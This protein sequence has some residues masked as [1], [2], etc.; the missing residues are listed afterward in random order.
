MSQTYA[1][2]EGS[3]TLTSSRAIINS[4]FDALKTGFSGTEPPFT[5]TAD[6]EGA[7]YFNTTDKKTYRVTKQGNNYVWLIPQEFVHSTGDESISGAKTFTSD[8]TAPNI[9]TLTS[10]VSTLS[11]TAAHLAGTETFTGNKTFSG[12]VALGSSATAETKTAGTNTTAVATTAFVK[13][14]V[15]VS[16]GSKTKPVYTN[17]SGILTASDANV[18]STT[19]PIYMD[20]GE[21]KAI[22]GAIANNVSGNAATAT[23]LAAQV[24][25]TVKDADETNAGTT[26]YTDGSSATV[27]LKLPS[28]IKATLSGNAATATKATQDADGNTI[29]STYAKVGSANTFTDTNVF[30]SPIILRNNLSPSTAT[31]KQ[32]TIDDILVEV[33]RNTNNNIDGCYVLRRQPPDGTRSVLYCAGFRNAANTGD[34]WS[35]IDVGVLPNDTTFVA[36]NGQ[37]VTAPT[38]AVATNDNRIATTQ[39]VNTKF[40][41][42]SSLPASPDANTFYFIPG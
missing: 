26:T 18:G 37:M 17:A 14:L 11:S 8:V 33:S 38:P 1:E 28:T 15:P 39:Y 32:T 41:V 10:T 31:A 9:T 42:V 22:T 7:T 3:T 36:L 4:N 23:K 40:Q 20:G 19:Q 12:T 34:L 5:A 21:L 13:L 27:V 24:G 16:I 25:V 2:L 6:V 30:N 35:V 29:S